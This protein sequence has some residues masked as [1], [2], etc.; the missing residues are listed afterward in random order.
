[1]LT[2]EAKGKEVCRKL[3]RL[4]SQIVDEMGENKD[5]REL[6]LG[7]WFSALMLNAFITF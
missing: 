3:L 2:L 5:G 7:Y 4:R 1:M 6:P